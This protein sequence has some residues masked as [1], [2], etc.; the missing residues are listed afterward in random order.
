MKR[1]FR[2]TFEDIFFLED[3]N[4]N[5][6]DWYRDEIKKIVDSREFSRQIQIIKFKHIMDIN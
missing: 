2:V 4:P 3:E 1:I 6:F 5:T